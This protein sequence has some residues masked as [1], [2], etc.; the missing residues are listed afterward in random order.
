VVPESVL[1]FLFIRRGNCP[2]QDGFLLLLDLLGSLLLD[3]LFDNRFANILLLTF[4][5]IIDISWM[6]V[7]LTLISPSTVDTEIILGHCR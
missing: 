5:L 6:E 4:I 7:L 3:I 1:E 2:S